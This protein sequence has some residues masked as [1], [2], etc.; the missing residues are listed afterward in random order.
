MVVA[1]HRLQSILSVSGVVR[2]CLSLLW[3]WWPFTWSMDT[4]IGASD[5]HTAWIAWT[6][7]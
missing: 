3:S 6:M 2:G 7:G 4:L 1:A 5:L